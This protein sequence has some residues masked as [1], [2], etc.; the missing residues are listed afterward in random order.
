MCRGRTGAAPARSND[1]L[2]QQ[3]AEISQFYQA[4]LKDSPAAIDYLKQRGLDGANRRGFWY[5]LRAG[6]LGRAARPFR[7]QTRTVGGVCN[8]TGMVIERD[9]GGFYDRFRNR[10]MFPIRDSRGRTIGFGGRVFGDGEPKYLNSP[11]T[12]LFKKGRA[13]YGLYEARQALRDISR[14]LVVEGY[15]DVVGLAQHGIRYA[16]ATLG[17]ATTVEHLKQLFRISSEVVFC[18]DGD[19]AGRAAAWRALENALPEVREGRDIRF[20]FLPDGEDPD[21]LVGKEGAEAFENRLKTALPLSEYLVVELSG[22]ADLAS[23]EG[24]ALLA[25]QARPLIARIPRGVYREML[26]RLV[27]DKVQ[28]A[29]ENLGQLLT[30]AAAPRSARP[31]R[32]LIGAAG[33][34]NLARKAI[35]HLLAHPRLALEADDVQ[36]LRDASQTGYQILAELIAQCQESPGLNTAALL[37]RW[38]DRPEGAHLHKLVSSRLEQLGQRSGLSPDGLKQE[39]CDLMDRIRGEL[40]PDRE[41]ALL[42]KLASDGLSAEEKEELRALHVARGEAPPA[43]ITVARR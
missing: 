27:A 34:S 6:Q 29:P 19:R 23:I 33:R 36:I 11:E 26:I 17:T 32:R 35:G 38:R 22:K 30:D 9:G 7:R 1:D 8:S 31:P 25:E 28:M 13:L 41:R 10:I 18:F 16:V 5:R 42:A 12:P 15:M 20:L 3:L 40:A 37:E 24:R 39:F 2:Y 14:L 21:S 4:Q 43:D